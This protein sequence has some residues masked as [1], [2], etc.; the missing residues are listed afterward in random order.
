MIIVGLFGMSAKFHECTLAQLYRHIEPDGTVHG[1]PMYYLHAG[2][3]EMGLGGLGKVLSVLFAILCV[4]G[5]FGGGN[6]FQANQ[7]FQAIASEIPAL[8][9]HG[10]LF[11]VV[12]AVLVGLVIIG[13][14]KRIGEVTEKLIPGMCGLYVLAG[15]FVLITHAPAIPAAFATIFREAFSM[16]AGLGGLLGVMVQGIRRAVF[17]NEAGVG[18][19]AIAHSAA[20]TDQPIREG[21]VALLEPFIDTVVICTMTGLVVVVTG[22]YNNPAAGAGVDMTRWAFADSISWFPAVLAVC[23]F[24]FA[25]STLISWSYYGEKAWGYLFGRNRTSI[26][27][28]KGIFLVFVVIGC[29][30][31]LQN[32]IEFSDMMILSMALPNIIGGIILAP[33]VKKILDEYWGKLQRNEFKTYK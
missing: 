10:L 18:S 20:K 28:Y 11:G 7:S 4:G 5:S 14:I 30:S 8:Q 21:M 16:E 22:A 32:V 31:S 33:K 1:G 19:A 15:L 25:Y 13:G 3:K 6:M 26:L 29:V 12:L 24:A 9:G 17:S 27:V 23:V 2:L